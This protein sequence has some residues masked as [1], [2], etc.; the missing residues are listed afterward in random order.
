MSLRWVSAIGALALTALSAWVPAAALSPASLERT[1][2]P[3]PSHHADAGRAPGPGMGQARQ[4]AADA[5]LVRNE[6]APASVVEAV[7]D[8]MGDWL[9]WVKDRDGDLWSCN[10]DAQGLIYVNVF[11][12][13]DML[14]GGGADFLPEQATPAGPG[15]AAQTRA[16]DLCLG[17]AG[18]TQAVSVVATT[19]DGLGD[20][21]VWLRLSDGQLWLC[22]ASADAELFVFEP[23]GFPVDPQDDAPVLSAA[24]PAS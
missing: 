10:A 24:G 20:T 12:G 18:L 14:E 16:R 1:A 11:V 19:L 6:F 23:V 17:V 2:A 5:C 22:D 15:E 7:P 13:G 9:V 21:L 4:A 3:A 8:G